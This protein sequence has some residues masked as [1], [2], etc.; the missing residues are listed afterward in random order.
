MR[1]FIFGH[2][3][4]DH[5]PPAIETPSDETTVPHWLHLFAQ[6]AGHGYAVTGQ[7]GFLQ[8]HQNL[9]PFA[10]W[11]YDIVPAVWDSDNETFDQADFNHVLITAANFAQWQGPSV[12]YYNDP[13]GTSPLSA[14]RTISDWLQTQEDSIKIFIY[15]NW[16][17]MAPYMASFPPTPEELSDYHDYTLGSF[18]DWWI[19]YH[20]SLLLQRPEHKIKMI[21]VG[22]ILAELMMETEVGNILVTEL[23]EDDAPHGRPTL[24]FLASMI[25]YMSM[26]QEKT[27]SSFTVPSIVDPIIA[28]NY[29][30]LVDFIWNRLLAFDTD[31]GN[32]R[33]FYDGVLSATQVGLDT[34]NIVVYPNP[35]A[36]VFRIKGN[37]EL[38]TIEVLDSVSQVFQTY[39]NQP[40]VVIDLSSLPAGMFFVRI[41]NIDEQQIFFQKII[42]L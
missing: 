21:P 31:N 13:N 42:K 24:Y 25:T 27:P 20:D 15:E 16:P 23:Y 26:Y 11:G 40:D 14:T 35:S 2:S 41:Q 17:D 3:L 30:T 29:G 7:Y 36:G 34:A 6:E 22:P 32:S 4:I 28:D 12:P 8:Q 1:Q 33:V 18:H 5:R 19:E 9:P 39:M 38:Y 37:T 10:Q